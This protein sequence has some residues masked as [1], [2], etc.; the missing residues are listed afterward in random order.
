MKISHLNLPLMANLIHYKFDIHTYQ[1]IQLWIITFLNFQYF[2]QF[3]YYVKYS[4]DINN[5]II[6][7]YSFFKLFYLF[8][9]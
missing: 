7:P 4:A 2:L 9:C 5:F 3:S 8:T 6:K 1:Y